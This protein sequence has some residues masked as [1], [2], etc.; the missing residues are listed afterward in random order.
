M[1]S[2]TITMKAEPLMAERF[3][4]YGEVLTH[5]GDGRRHFVER[6]FETTDPAARPT[7]WINRILHPAP[8]APILIDQVERH[9]HSFQTLIPLHAARFFVAV[10]HSLPDGTPDLDNLR[11]FVTAPG[12]GV[13]YHPNVWHFGF[14]AL[15]GPNEVVVMIGVTGREDDCIVSVVDRRVEV[16]W[17]LAAAG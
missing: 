16:E 2:A 12:Q 11:P 6:A 4:P 9:P 8:A 7:M 17:D 13:T 3:A 10:T 5:V 1:L 15:D 14:T